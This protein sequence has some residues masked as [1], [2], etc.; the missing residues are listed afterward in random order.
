VGAFHGI[1]HRLPN[2]YR[3]NADANRY[4]S[5]SPISRI[6]TVANS[7]NN[8]CIVASG[9]YTWVR[10]KAVNETTKF[11]Q[12]VSQSVTKMTRPVSKLTWSSAV[13]VARSV[14]CKVTSDR[15]SW[16][17]LKWEPARSTVWLHRA[18]LNST[19]HRA[20]PS[21]EQYSQQTSKQQ[22]RQPT[23]TT[24][25]PAIAINRRP[26]T[27]RAP[28]HAPHNASCVFTERANLQPSIN[29]G[30]PHTGY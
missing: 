8:S 7:R 29:C 10:L 28:L 24:S 22:H 3:G 27:S 9:V 17:R 12:S 2:R 18:S 23:S 5:N 30:N 25:R 6:S 16:R 19:P 26:V 20:S 14:S 15:R 21:E 1:L 13:R 4:P 11:S